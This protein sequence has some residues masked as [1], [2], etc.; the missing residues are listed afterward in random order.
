MNPHPSD[1]FA[2]SRPENPSPGSRLYLYRSLR[3][4]ASDGDFS[5]VPGQS[6]YQG[7]KQLTGR[8]GLRSPEE[9]TTF[10][11][12]LGLGELRHQISR[13]QIRLTLAG[14]PPAA[15]AGSEGGDSCEFER[16]LIDGALEIITGMPVNTEET[17]CRHLGGAECV[18]EAQMQGGPA[19]PRYLPAADGSR[20]GASRDFISVGS[21]SGLADLRSW[22]LDLAGR[23]LAR[24]KRHNRLLA[25]LYID[26]DDLGEI[27][28]AYGRRAGDQV[29]G[30][31]AAALGK[32]CRCEDFIWHHGEDEFAV[33]LTETDLPGARIVASRLAVEILSAAEFVDISARISASIGVAS[34]PKH[35]NTVNGLINTAR[36]ALYMAKASGKGLVQEA[37]GLPDTGRSR[38]EM[39]TGAENGLQPGP[40]SDRAPGKSAK[41]RAGRPSPG[42]FGSAAGD[43]AGQSQ[44]RPNSRRRPGGDHRQT[45]RVHKTRR[46]D[47]SGSATAAQPAGDPGDGGDPVAT[48]LL[49]SVSPVLIAGMKQVVLSE[50]ATGASAMSMIRE[51]T[52]FQKLAD[53]VLDERPDIIFTDMQMVA[54]ED[55]AFPKLLSE[56]NLPCKI[57][58]FVNDVSPDVLKLVA[59]YSVDGVILQQTPTAEAMEAL[60]AIYRGKQFL[61]DEVRTAMIQLEDSRRLLRD[62][63][64]REL[65]VL[66]LVAE[67]KSNS[68]ISEELYIT[69]NTV[70]FHLANVYQKLGV[71]NRTEAAK[72]FLRQDLAPNG[73][74]QLL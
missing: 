16:G 38:S 68:Q 1:D 10:F 69:V 20:Q 41:L 33:L 22:Y 43:E 66:R 54:T 30:A 7:A 59:D 55:F 51:I 15:G 13:E 26:L 70:R 25:L 29:I 61:P 39:G 8:L 9:L 27:N 24:A 6:P 42:M 62:L 21:I 52:D 56:E 34:F 63:S 11:R 36:S 73:Q 53:A 18:F 3:L 58:V 49:A 4:L 14:E 72:Y 32:S 5:L 19:A 64:E 57:V 35:S 46:Q 28:Q 12:D 45:G 2:S 47:D 60:E 74:T 17:G 44:V 40:D 23:E 65:E 50:T 37:D 48:V 31:V 67:G 71:G